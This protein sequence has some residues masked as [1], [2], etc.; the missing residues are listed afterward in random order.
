MVKRFLNSRRLTFPWGIRILSAAPGGL[1]E[2]IPYHIR[3]KR[4]DNIMSANL[5]PSAGA[6]PRRMTTLAILLASPLLLGFASSRAL[7]DNPSGK[8]NL[9]IM[10]TDDQ[11]FDALSCAGNK[12]LKT[13]NMDRIANEG[14]RF[15]NM[16]VINSLCAPSR[17]TIL[18]GQ[19]SHTNGVIDNKNR[20]INKDSPFFP[21]L[22]RQAGYEVAFCGKSHVQGA[23]RD[24]IWDYY[25]GFLGQGNY[26]MPRV[27][28][29][30]MTKDMAYEGW[31]DD[32]VTGKAIDWLKKKH[33][34]PFCLFLWFKAPHRSWDRAPRH[35]DLFKDVTIP[36]PET[37]DIGMKGDP[38]KPKAFNEA[39]NKIGNAKDVKSL[40][41]VKDYYAV[42]TGVDE[43]VGQVL[44]TLK[45]INKLD[46][47]LILFTSDNGFFTG[48]WGRY[49]KRFMHEP[50]IRVPLLVRYPKLIKPGTLCDRMVLNVDFA[51]TMLEMAGVPVPRTMH[52]RSL[53][54][55]FKDPRAAW[56]QDWLYEYFEFPGPHSVKMNRGIRTERYKLIHYY[57]NPEEFEL[58][59]LEKDPG[60]RENLYGKAEFAELTKTLMARLQELRKETGELK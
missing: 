29:G 28:E 10:M 32:V 1:L 20:S 14:C 30:T 44:D 36:K 60:E 25:F 17:A 54:P 37:Y 18:T 50:S 6:S 49:D 21:E 35:K 8:P 53:V 22:L 34:K 5:D 24:R 4:K 42:L 39:D 52:G 46:D 55:L 3:V 27:A 57:E 12:I 33:D 23:L 15:R 2:G 51:P 47:T 40:D 56:R 7:A 59:D 13:P 48:E 31:M 26:L 9:I 58:Y 43:N 11:R 38:A 19:Y 45:E 41:F 16:F